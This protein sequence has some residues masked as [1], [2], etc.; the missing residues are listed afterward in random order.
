MAYVS[1]FGH[2]FLMGRWEGLEFD[3]YLLKLEVGW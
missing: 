3:F 2:I 1:K